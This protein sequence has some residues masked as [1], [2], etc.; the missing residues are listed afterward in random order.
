ME[1]LYQ[2]SIASKMAGVLHTTSF[3]LLLFTYL[4][5]VF[6][7]LF[8]YLYTLFIYHLLCMAARLTTTF[9]FVTFITYSGLTSSANTIFEICLVLTPFILAFCSSYYEDT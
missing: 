1:C 7:Y 8:I 9:L 5:Y 2:T 4:Y 3:N 6:I